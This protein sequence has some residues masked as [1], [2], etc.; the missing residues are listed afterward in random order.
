MK[1]AVN[2]RLLLKNKLEGIGWFMFETLRR[3]VR[4][5][6][7]H[8]F[9]FIFDRKYDEK[10]IF[11]NN[12][13]PVVIGP[14]AR[15]VSLFYIWFEYAI[16]HAL[17]KIKPDVFV[18]PDAYNSLRS[19]FKSLIVI[20]DLNFE[21][22]PEKMPWL[23]RKYYRYFTPLFARKADR[24]A[25]VSE[26]SKNDIVKQYSIDPTK[27]D[28]V[29]NGVNKDYIPVN[30]NIKLEIKEKYTGGSDFFVYVGAL[31]DRKNLDNLF[32]AFDMFKKSAAND[33]KLLIVGSK[34]WHNKE[35]E[36]TYE[37][38]QFKADV[39]FTGRLPIEE[40]CRA[41]AS[42]M[43]M[44]YVSYF[45]GFGI[46]ILEAFAAGVPVITSNVTSMPEVAGDAAIL[47][48]PFDVEE[49]SSAMKNIAENESLRENLIQKGFQRCKAF[50]WDVSAQNLWRSIEKTMAS[51]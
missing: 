24:I 29:Y 20:H 19:P 38:M 40:L 37:S 30:E 10:F 36:L 9:Y 25:T 41:T 42:A 21:H 26:F 12:V 50:S 6:P 4:D 1:I 51:Q 33:I 2:T 22:Y 28:V 18:S 14:P 34:M 5:H 45:E 32:K 7:E 15:H 48:D 46:P 35:L 17:K 23:I 47:V 11:A 27:I 43:V 31:I 8:T 39:I 3:I 16:P 44:T 49:I 13:I